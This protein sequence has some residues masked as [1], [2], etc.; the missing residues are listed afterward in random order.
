M[1]RNMQAEAD[2]V[3]S[4]LAKEWAPA[5]PDAGPNA[6]DFF[7]WPIQ[8]RLMAGVPS[9]ALEKYLKWGAEE[10][11]GKPVAEARIKRTV[12]MLQALKLADTEPKYRS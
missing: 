3:R 6:Y 7:V 9:A 5:G 8:K 12:E 1:P 2:M 10:V 4:V 11:I